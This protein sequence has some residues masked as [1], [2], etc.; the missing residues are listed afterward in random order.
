MRIQELRELS[1]KTSYL[2][3]GYPTFFYASSC[4]IGRFRFGCPIKVGIRKCKVFRE[5]YYP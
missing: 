3:L 2:P 1:F 5:K 4:R